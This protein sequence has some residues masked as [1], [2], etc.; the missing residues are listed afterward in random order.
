M[1]FRLRS[2]FVPIVAISNAACLLALE[3]PA[4]Q[5]NSSDPFREAVVRADELARM[6]KKAEAISAYEKAMALAPELFGRDKPK[7]ASVE[8]HPSR[9][10]TEAATIGFRLAE[11]YRETR[12][13]AKAEPLYE[14]SLRRRTAQ[15]GPTHHDVAVSLYGLGRL[16]QA[17][18]RFAEA[19][20]LYER[21]MEIWRRQHGA[22]HPDVVA[23]VKS[24]ESLH[25]AVEQNQPARKKSQ[26]AANQQEPVKAKRAEDPARARL[27]AAGKQAYDALGKDAY[28]KATTD[29]FEQV[30]A[31]AVTTLGPEHGEVLLHRQILAGMLRA[32]GRYPEAET[33]YRLNLKILEVKSGPDH[34]SVAMCLNNLAGLYMDQ[35]RYREAEPLA[36]RALK[37]L[38]ARFG[39][40]NW[41]VVPTLRSLASLY[42]YEARFAE[43]EPLLTRGLKIDEAALGREEDTALSLNALAGLYKKTG[44]AAEAE[45]LLSR[46][47]TIH[48]AQRRVDH[49]K[50]AVCLNE[51]AGLYHSQ[52]RYVEAEAHY[53]RCVRIRERA[54]GLDHPDVAKSLNN[55]AVLC[56]ELGR[57]AEA[58]SLLKRSL[59]I[60]ESKLGSAHPAV[61]TVLVHLACIRAAQRD[62]Q[63]AAATFDRARHASVEHTVRVLPAL[64]EKEQLDFLKATDQAALHAALSIALGRSPDRE[65]AGWSVGWVLNGK[66]R[67]QQSLAERALLARR[68]KN[69]D[70]ARL[71]EQLRDVRNRLAALTLAAPRS[72]QEDNRK[73]ELA[74][75]EQRER[76]LSKEL[77]QV[78]G[79]RIRDDAW[80]G[81]DAVRKAVPDHAVLVEVVRLDVLD[82][83]P[84]D[85]RRRWKPAHYAAWIIPPAGQ[86]N[87]VVIDLGEA[88]PIDD[89]VAAARRALQAEFELLRSRGEPDAEQQLRRPLGE[90][91]RLVLYP[92]LPH[93]GS[94]QR[95]LISPDAALWLVPWAALPLPGG[96]YA[97]EEHLI[98]YL[99]SGRELAA[100]PGSKA[101]GRPI[102]LADP[103]YDL[104]LSRARAVAQRVKPEHAAALNQPIVSL[105]GTARS[106]AEA[107]FRRLPGTAAEAEAILPQITRYAHTE[108][109]YYAGPEALEAV[110]KSVNRPQI[111][112]L[113]TH[114]FF[115]DE[116]APRPEDGKVPRLSSDG[117]LPTAGTDHLPENP[118][119]RC[120]LILAGANQ[121]EKANGPEDDDGILTGMEIVGTDLQGT[122]LVV[123]SACETGVGQV[124]TGEGLAGLRQAFQLAGAQ[125]VIATLW[126]VPDRESARLMMGF[127]DNLAKGQGKAEALRQAQLAQI[128]SRRERYGAAH[129]FFWAAYTLTGRGE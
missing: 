92:L 91:A 20:S 31:L 47:L 89:A 21:A 97:I 23:C 40:D 59:A 117:G 1:S 105:R 4:P 26:R 29:L 7:T 45:S 73:R 70:A 34:P 10:P 123:L 107:V 28:S 81:P 103:D 27:K 22:D 109:R 2:W 57:D 16:Y 33:L 32:Q 112:M 90:L 118:L 44:R 96:R 77:G 63:G 36:T 5:V 17:T 78:T 79:Q 102:V 88:K 122:E 99:V 62:W 115:L 129:P 39:V 114:G 25:Q 74:R 46:S 104:D 113:S 72:G 3:T 49:L 42:M 50:V 87:V 93:I 75:L 80:V 38:E 8:H 67:A 52:G 54:L 48:E 120:G 76:E 110:F 15:L 64:A 124:R 60:L 14:L 128:K 69:P 108:P 119:L 100:D 12:D 11:L 95:W 98:S 66:A 41:M 37:I 84:N 83:Q 56:M 24:I 127:F 116:P 53:R 111:V 82:F 19:E 85:R 55:L 125:A 71:V 18:R 30:V 51:L 68:G 65:A 58:E 101:T 106:H 6:G 9:N 35:G 13:Y 43:A 61:A 94:D 121:R 126:Q 86:G